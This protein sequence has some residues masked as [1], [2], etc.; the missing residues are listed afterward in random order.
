MRES[1]RE[2]R[3][4]GVRRWPSVDDSRGMRWHALSIAEDVNRSKDSYHW[5]R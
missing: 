1:A 5:Q 4:I 2:I 3:A